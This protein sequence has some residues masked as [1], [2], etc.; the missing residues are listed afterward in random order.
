MT[1]VQTCALP[2]C[3][4][5]AG[6]LEGRDLEYIMPMMP[7]RVLSLVPADASDIRDASEANLAAVD[8][9]RFRSSLLKVLAVTFGAVAAVVAVLALVPLARSKPAA[10]EDRHRVPDRAL[11]NHAAADLAATQSRASGEGWNEDLIARALA[12]TRVIAA[13]AIGQ[14]ISQKVL[15]AGDARPEGRLIV[16][17]GL[18]RKTSASISSSVTADEVQRASGAFSTTRQH[19]LEG[20]QSALSTFSNAL[21]RKEPV[22]DASA[23]DDAVRQA[24]A[25]A[26][27]VAAERRWQGMPWATR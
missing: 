6:T 19:Q 10:A 5:A 17:H 22:R 26:K 1:G 24:I 27:D 20:L 21:Y 23:L 3:V 13:A 12:S 25:V 11:L 18:I 8:S 7:I 15:P 14:P 4:G 9:M 2:I 16:H